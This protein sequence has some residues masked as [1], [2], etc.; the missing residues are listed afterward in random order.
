MDDFSFLVLLVGCARRFVR[1][2]GWFGFGVGG[3]IASAA[4]L[5]GGG[6]SG[7]SSFPSFGF[8]DE[9]NNAF[10][11]EPADEQAKAAADNQAGNIEEVVRFANNGANF[12][13][14]IHVPALNLL[15]GFRADEQAD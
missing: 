1:F 5:F 4:S 9:P 6:D 2:A 12:S 8:G 7:G 11:A 14:W 15:G 3:G 13:G 10:G